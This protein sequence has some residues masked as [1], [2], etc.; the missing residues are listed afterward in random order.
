M[1][2]ILFTQ[3][4]LI[5]PFGCVAAMVAVAAVAAVAA[6]SWL[7][8]GIKCLN[9]VDDD[10][11][12]LKFITI[13]STLLH[14]CNFYINRKSTKEVVVVQLNSQ[15]LKKNFLWTSQADQQSYVALIMDHTV[16]L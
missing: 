13:I 6:V 15:V 9:L 8:R 5:E 16:S 1:W 14:K 2:K 12:N 3:A 7:K 10:N 11:Y 4:S